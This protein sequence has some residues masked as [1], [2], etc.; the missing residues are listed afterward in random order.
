MTKE[1]IQIGQ[2]QLKQVFNAF[3]EKP[4]TMKEV[5][6][7][8]GIMRENICRY[9]NMLRQQNKLFAV[10]KRRCKVTGY[11][12]VIEW[13]TNPIFAPKQPLQLSLFA[14]L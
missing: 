14:E 11:P 12:S 9:C 5:D 10:R 3:F 2:N 7:E 4:R 1:E 13:T 6:K 8:T